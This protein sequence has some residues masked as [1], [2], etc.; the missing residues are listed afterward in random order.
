MNNFNVIQATNGVEGLDMLDK[1]KIDLVIVDIM[2]EN[3]EKET[4]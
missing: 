2:I 1:E 3:Q 4:K